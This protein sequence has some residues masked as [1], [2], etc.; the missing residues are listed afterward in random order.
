MKSNNSLLF[1]ALYALSFSGTVFS[2]ELL[3][4]E[5]LAFNSLAEQLTAEQLQN[6]IRMNELWG[7]VGYLILPLLLYL[8]ILLVATALSIGTFF[9][10]HEIKFS[11]IFNIA[12]KAEYVFLLPMVFQFVWF[13]FFKTDFTLEELQNFMPLSLGSVF[14]FEHFEP[15]FIYP[16]QAVNLFEVAYWFILA[17][18]LARALQITRSQAFTIVASSYGVGF[19]IWV[20]TVSFIVLNFS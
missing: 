14:G 2:A 18:L 7:W 13:Y 1:F 10:E 8:K 4:T 9:F 6:V 12:V 15:W 5:Q 3:G 20:A 19:L 17:F 16:L 11:R